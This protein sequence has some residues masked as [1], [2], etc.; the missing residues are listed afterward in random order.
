MVASTSGRGW[1]TDST[2]VTPPPPASPASMSTTAAAL[3]LSSPAGHIFNAYGCHTR[4]HTSLY[5]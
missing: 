5:D 1:C 3:V 2:T 4:F